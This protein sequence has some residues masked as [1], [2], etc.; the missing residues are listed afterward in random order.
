LLLGFDGLLSDIVI[1][2]RVGLSELNFML[3]NVNIPILE[4]ENEIIM[5]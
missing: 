1:A 4:I 2:G 3:L 5:A